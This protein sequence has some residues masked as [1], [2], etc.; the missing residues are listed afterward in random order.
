MG[1]QVL[2]SSHRKK[3]LEAYITRHSLGG[4]AGTE[5]K[6]WARVSAGL[7]STPDWGDLASAASVSLKIGRSDFEGPYLLSE[8][9][10][11]CP[12]IKPNLRKKT[13]MALP[14]PRPRGQG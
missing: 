10:I 1:L 12:Y 13:D 2:K 5:W 3:D 9:R 6:E 14:V 4:S 7:I 11:L 8:L